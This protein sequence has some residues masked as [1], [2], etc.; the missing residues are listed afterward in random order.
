MSPLKNHIFLVKRLKNRDNMK[1]VNVKITRKSRQENHEI[2][3]KSVQKYEHL[4]KDNELDYL[5]N[6]EMKTSNFYGLPKIHK[7]N[8]IKTVIKDLNQA[9]ITTTEHLDLK[10]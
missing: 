2:F 5:T 8:H 7:R 10:L 1:A 9:Y 4:L 6:F 3:E